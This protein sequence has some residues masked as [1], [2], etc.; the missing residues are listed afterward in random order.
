MFPFCFVLANNVSNGDDELCLR[1]LAQ[2]HLKLHAFTLAEYYYSKLKAIN[3]NYLECLVEQ[4]CSTKCQEV[5]SSVS[6]IENDSTLTEEDCCWL[7][8]IR[9]KYLKFFQTIFCLDKT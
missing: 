1:L 4:K 8:E 3:V 9:V 5:I 6:K 2:T 7:I